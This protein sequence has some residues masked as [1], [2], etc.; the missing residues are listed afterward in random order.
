MSNR[1]KDNDPESRLE[2]PITLWYLQLCC[3]WIVALYPHPIP[4]MAMLIVTNIAY[5]LFLVIM[6]PFII[7]INTIVSVIWCMA[8][9]TL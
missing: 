8:L 9:I 4:Q 1:I 3:I 7:P 2:V 5:I 6:R